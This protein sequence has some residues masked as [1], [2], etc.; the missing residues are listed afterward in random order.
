MSD[1]QE[2]SKLEEI[3]R[4]VEEALNDENHEFWDHFGE[5]LR[6][7]EPMEEL[8]QQI[9]EDDDKKRKDEGLEPRP[10]TE[11]EKEM[12]EQADHTLET[13]DD[14]LMKWDTEQR[15]AKGLEARSK[16]EME[17]ELMPQIGGVVM[18][19]MYKFDTRKRKEKGLE[20]RALK[21]FEEMMEGGLKG[22]L[23]A[24]GRE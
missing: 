11:I 6:D 13:F 14:D 9:Q 12:E 22:G 16:E 2:V 19:V 8:R 4:R 5:S 23:E 24:L 7:D 20:P 10:W 15:K 3:A 17:E 18:E 21:E 1:T